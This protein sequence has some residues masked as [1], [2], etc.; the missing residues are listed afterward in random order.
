MESAE[1]RHPVSL[2][3]QCTVARCGETM[4]LAVHDRSSAVYVDKSDRS[5]VDYIAATGE[6]ASR[7]LGAIL[8]EH[9]RG[10]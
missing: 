2:A 6:G 1:Y 7:Q 3:L 10:P 4:H 5:H 9:R 8:P